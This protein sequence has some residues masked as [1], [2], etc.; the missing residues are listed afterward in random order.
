[1]ETPLEKERWLC[2]DPAANDA[3][4]ISLDKLC[5]SAGGAICQSSH[6]LMNELKWRLPC[7]KVIDIR[8]QGAAIRNLN[9]RSGVLQDITV[10][11]EYGGGK[12]QAL[13][14]AQPVSLG[15]R[16]IQDIKRRPESTRVGVRNKQVYCIPEC[17]AGLCWLTGLPENRPAVSRDERLAR[18]SRLEIVEPLG[19][20]SFGGVTPCAIPG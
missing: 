4:Q 5:R 14:F 19:D 8:I 1:V 9:M 16:F 12:S 17:I 7:Q 10:R 18:A 3:R 20:A 15:R 6:N 13:R 2:D 11:M